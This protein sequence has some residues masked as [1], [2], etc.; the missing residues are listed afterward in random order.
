[1]KNIIK[2]GRLVEEAKKS[3]YLPNVLLAI[4]IVH[5]F[6]FLGEYL[7]YIGEYVIMPLTGYENYS[8]L[9]TIDLISSNIGIAALVFIWVWFVE[10]R[11]VSS[12][13]LYRNEWFKNYMKGVI[14]G[15]L[16]FS[17]LTAIL[18]IT[19]NARINPEPDMIVGLAAI[20]SVLII[21]PGWIVQGATE[22]IL[23]RGWLLN[24]V[25]AKYNAAVGIL[26]SSSF[27]S[28]MHIFNDGVS[29][30]AMTNLIL[31]GML[32]SLYVFRTGNIWGACGAHFAWNWVQ[33]N[34]FGLGVSG[35]YYGDG[36]LIQLS[37]SGN[38]LLTGGYYGPEGGIVFT[39]VTVLFILIVLKY[40]LKKDLSDD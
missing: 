9:G 23:V 6:I 3:R 25:S 28:L 27:F 11:R 13:G 29:V 37:L 39:F 21:M 18:L 15:F 26:V 16:Q 35:S 14:F 10:K 7:L 22:E 8:L 38:E 19:G 1:M 2:N 32:F 17:T 40:P 5:A 31:D 36:T 33:G 20:S 4:V 30:L 12:I 34:I 24:T